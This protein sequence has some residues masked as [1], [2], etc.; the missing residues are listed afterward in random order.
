MLRSLHQY[1]ESDAIVA[2]LN[3]VVVDAPDSFYE[4]DE[5]SLDAS[6]RVQRLLPRIIR[7]NKHPSFFRKSGH[8]A[9]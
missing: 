8:V 9:G 6:T 4:F 2:G 7:H 5:T 1:I 3:R